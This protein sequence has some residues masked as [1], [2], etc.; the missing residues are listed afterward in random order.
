MIGSECALQI[1]HRVIYISVPD[2][3]KFTV[4]VRTSTDSLVINQSTEYHSLYGLAEMLG[5]IDTLKQTCKQSVSTPQHASNKVPVCE[6]MSSGEFG[7][8]G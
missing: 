5:F 7:T 3:R 6:R 4:L 1:P 8:S 2:V